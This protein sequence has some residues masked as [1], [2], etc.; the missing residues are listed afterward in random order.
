MKP[1]PKPLAGLAAVAAVLLLSAGP[2]A[3]AEE[4]AIL[5]EFNL[6]VSLGGDLQRLVGGVSFG[7]VL[8]NGLWWS[9]GGRLG[10]MRYDNGRVDESGVTLGGTIGV[11]IDPSRRLS[12]VAGL[13]VDYPFGV[14]DRVRLLTQVHAGARIRLRPD[15]EHF[16][17]TVAA[18]WSGMFLGSGLPDDSDVGVAVL[19]SA[20]VHERR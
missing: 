18:F 20:A 2:A 13:A 6:D 4:P 1:F 10:G 11:G 8:P 9:W 3:A 5:D 15:V 7:S 16:T 12:P 19:L 14:D 17:V